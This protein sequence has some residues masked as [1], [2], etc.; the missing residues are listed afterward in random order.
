MDRHGK[1]VGIIVAVLIALYLLWKR[2]GSAVSATLA[3]KTIPASTG[4][5]MAAATSNPYPDNAPAVVPYSPS[6]APDVTSSSDI[7]MGARAFPFAQSDAH[8]VMSGLGVAD[9]A[10]I[11]DQS[12]QNSSTG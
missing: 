7:A 10:N 4:T 1:A 11:Q 9:L 2:G 6:P 3:G 12:F 5:A 8:I